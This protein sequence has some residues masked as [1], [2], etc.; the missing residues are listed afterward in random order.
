MNPAI[1]VQAI[2]LIV[3]FRKEIGKWFMDADQHSAR[4]D[5]Q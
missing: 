2:V 3:I 1:L 4:E 5:K